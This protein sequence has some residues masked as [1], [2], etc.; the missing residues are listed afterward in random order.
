MTQIE[1]IRQNIHYTRVQLNRAR[2]GVYNGE[3]EKLHKWNMIHSY[4]DELQELKF[5]LKCAIKQQ[6]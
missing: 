4:L 6:N 2:R 5:S 3:I 1:S